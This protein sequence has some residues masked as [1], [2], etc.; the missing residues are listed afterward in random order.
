[1]VSA[2]FVLLFGSLQASLPASVSSGWEAWA[3]PKVTLWKNISEMR[4]LVNRVFNIY[5][6]LFDSVGVLGCCIGLIFLLLL[7]VPRQRQF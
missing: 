2:S 5:F 1:M 3:T 7:L 4:R 6:V